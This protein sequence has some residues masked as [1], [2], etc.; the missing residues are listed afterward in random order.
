[1]QRQFSKKQNNHDFFD[2]DSDGFVS[3]QGS[4]GMIL[5]NE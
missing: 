2:F 5:F 4:T 1:M 3:D